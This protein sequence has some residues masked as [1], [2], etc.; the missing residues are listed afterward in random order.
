MPFNMRKNAFLILL[1]CS[2]IPL[3]AVTIHTIGDS[4]MANYDSM[5]VTR[6]WGMYLGLFLDDSVR[7]NN[8]AK[9]GSSTRTYYENDTLWTKVKTQIVRGDYVFIQFAHNDEKSNGAD[10]EQLIEYYTSVGDT[11]KADSVD[12]RGTTPATTYIQNL[13]R[14][15]TE[16]RAL[17]AIPVLIAPAARMYFSADTI[18]RAGLHDLGDKFTIVTPHGVVEG[19]KVPAA[20]HSMDYVWHMRQ[21]A[22]EM[23][24]PFMDLT[25]ATRQLYERLGDERC[26]QLLS[27]GKGH[28]HFSAQGAKQVAKLCAILMKQ[29][30]I[31]AEHVKAEIPEE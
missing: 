28:T 25:T 27:D 16:A 15:V 9:N 17:G 2:L 29:N 22:E 20:D 24:V 4:T 30:M 21:V 19:N 7:V 14:Y 8:R 5:R 31:L 18:R 6:G 3:R 1:L 11:A 12:R 10:A 23:Q 13:R 26:H